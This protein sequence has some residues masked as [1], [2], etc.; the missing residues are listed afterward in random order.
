MVDRAVARLAD[1]QY[2][3]VA[4]RQ[5]LA[6]GLSRTMI[7]RRLRRAA[8]VRL[9]RGVYAVGHRRL[10]RAGFWMAAVL[11]TGDAAVLSHRDA[12]ALHGLRRPHGGRTDV[13]TTSDAR[14]TRAILVHQTVALPVEDVTVVDGIPATAVSRTLVDLATVIPRHQLEAALS[15]AERHDLLDVPALQA[16]ARRT[17]GRRGRGHAKLSKALERHAAHGV[18]IT[19]SELEQLFLALLDA[20]GLPRPS[21]NAIVEGREVDAYWPQRRFAVELDGWEFHKTRADFERDRAKRTELR[22]LGYDV[23]EFTHH[24]LTRRA[25]WVVSQLRPLLGL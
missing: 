10:S 24:Q 25:Q 21:A 16:V 1:R 12:A 17:W 7:D 3:V 11:A 14:S 23:T 9:H 18:T 5:L 20:E 15:E 19:R 13:T 2:G 22:A 4:R 6:L 8:F